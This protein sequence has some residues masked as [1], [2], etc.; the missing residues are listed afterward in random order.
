MQVSQQG[1]VSEGIWQKACESFCVY[2]NTCVFVD[3]QSDQQLW[4]TAVGHLSRLKC[5]Y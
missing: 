4:P 5:D 2:G 3:F 1:E